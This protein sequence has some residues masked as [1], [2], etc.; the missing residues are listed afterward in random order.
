MP[1]D[2]EA[3]ARKLYRAG[4]LAV[5]RFARQHAG[6]EVCFFAFDADPRQGYV[7]VSLDTLANNTRVAKQLERKAILSR[8]KN[9]QGDRAWCQA[10]SQLST[11]AVSPFNTNTGDFA[12]PEY[13][14][15]EFPA[16]RRLAE[17]ADY[18]A[19]EYVES[20]AR[21]V[22]W[23]VV[24]QLVADEAF[25]ALNRASP[26]LVGYGIHDQEAVILRLLNWPRGV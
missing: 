12:Y 3:S 13:V 2:W 20:N 14:A 5:R 1:V 16:W 18:P 23:R 4:A 11:P 26:F 17:R 7:F 22:L 21:L 10:K 6:L 9:L 19:E 8:Q 15:V 25:L 24:E